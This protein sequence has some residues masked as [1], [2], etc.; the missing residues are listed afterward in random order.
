MSNRAPAADSASWLY[1][2]LSGILTD[3]AFAERRDKRALKSSH[4][5]AAMTALKYL[6]GDGDTG[7]TR[8]VSKCLKGIPGDGT[9]AGS[10][11]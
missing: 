10:P 1:S 3:G 7:D 4:R 2:T 8:A 9:L 6:T 11:L 5:R